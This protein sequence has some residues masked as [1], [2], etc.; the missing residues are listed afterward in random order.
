MKNKKVKKPFYKK[1]WFWILIL[2]V[3]IG[4]GAGAGAIIDGPEKVGQTSAK[5]QDKSTETN[6]KVQDKSAEANTE[7]NKSTNKSK[8]FKIGDVVKLKD[9]KVTVNKVYKDKGDEFTQPQPGNEFIAVDCSVENISNEQQV[10]SS[11]MMFKV[12]D[13]DGR[14]C[15]ESIGGSTAANAGQMDGEVGPGRKI[16]GV[17][18]VEVP[19]GTTGLELEFN[20]S[21]LLGE[22]VIVKLN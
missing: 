3:G 5:V 8:I 9:F 18:V 17:Y 20:G 13:K 10:V 16:T 19:K 1:W 21:L 7:A 2:I 12:V 11:V 15:E 14:E 6:A 4:I 22:Q